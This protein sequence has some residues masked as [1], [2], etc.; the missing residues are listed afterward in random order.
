[1]SLLNLPGRLNAEGTKARHVVR[2]MAALAAC[3][4]LSGCGNKEAA[5]PEPAPATRP[6][7]EEAPAAGAAADMTPPATEQ[8]AQPA[9]DSQASTPA[10]QPTSSEGQPRPWRRGATAATTAT[11]PA[12][13]Q[14]TYETASPAP[15]AAQSLPQTQPAPQATAVNQWQPEAS[16]YATSAAPYTSYAANPYDTAG[17]TATVSSPAPP[18]T[19]GITSNLNSS[20]SQ[21]GLQGALG[22]VGRTLLGEAAAR[23]TSGSSG[24]SALRADTVINRLLP[25]ADVSSQPA[26]T[27]A[28]QGGG[29]AISNLLPSSLLPGSAAP[30]SMM[31][32]QLAPNSGASSYAAQPSATQS[33]AAQSTPTMSAQ[34]YAAPSSTTPV[35]LP[36]TTT[37]QPVEMQGSAA[38]SSAWPQASTD[39]NSNLASAPQMAARSSLQSASTLGA[40]AA[41][42]STPDQAASAPPVPAVPAADQASQENYT[43]VKVFYGTDRAR[44][45]LSST[46]WLDYLAKFY[47]AIATLLLAIIC[48]VC[49]AM[50]IGRGATRP[51]AWFATAGTVVLAAWGGLGAVKL[52][53]TATKPGVAYGG[54]RGTLEVGVCEV[55]IPP[56]HEV[57]ELE[58][59]TILRLEVREDP[60][61]HVVLLGTYPQDAAEFFEQLRNRVASSPKKDA[62]VFVHGYN[63]SFEDAARRTAQMAH[64][65]NFEGAPIFY[66]WPSQAQL[67]AYTVD[68]NNVEWTVPHLKEFLMDV[69]QQSGA[70][71]I[72]LIAHSMGNRALTKAL[73]ALSFRM[74]RPVFREVVLTAPDIDADVFRRDLA[75]QI[76]RTADRVTLYASSN[77]EALRVSKQIHGAPRA[78]DS[79]A[80]LVVVPGIETIDVSGIDTSLLGHSYY[81]SNGTVLSDLIGLLKY[82]M[83]ASQR[84]WLLPRDYQGLPY[85]V[86]AAATASTGTSPSQR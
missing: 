13:P 52:H 14:N 62:F 41:G 33:F 40:Q 73:H 39:S 64:D 43:T 35:P 77:D 30:S 10:T 28:G 67:A 72:C 61:K 81:G 51:L 17:G 68:E 85:W 6:A 65:L 1:M 9:N 18:S 70:E 5:D 8:P 19:Q 75:P 83:P 20:S 56:K 82:G 37:T 4:M 47:L 3:A 54:G 22:E 71:S 12:G 42:E 84:S 29:S 31:P 23:A 86:F 48:F 44:V 66:S 15:V 78:G 32:S 26:G 58:A 63:V 57:G 46:S 69:A 24:G 45:D 60:T 80:L 59:P 34:S 55:S 11:P 21:G 2:L 74:E 25:G 76:V 53:Q 79:G 16:A 36:S 49:A 27:T 50:N 38:A 7:G